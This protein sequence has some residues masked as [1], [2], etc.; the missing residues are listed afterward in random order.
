MTTI[1]KLIS[2]LLVCHTQVHLVPATCINNPKYSYGYDERDMKNCQWVERTEE[3][4]SVY[5]LLPVLSHHILQLYPQHTLQVQS[6]Q[7]THPPPLLLSQVIVPVL[8]H[9]ILQ[10]Y[11]HLNHRV[12]FHQQYHPVCGDG[13]NNVRQRFNGDI[14]NCDECRIAECGS[15]PGNTTSWSRREAFF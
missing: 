6:H 13:C 15:P 14:V 1:L 8:S 10:L 9:H 12:I 2:A 5:C 7:Q 11:M 3:R 4:R